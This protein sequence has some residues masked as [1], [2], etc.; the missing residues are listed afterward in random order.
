MSSPAVF[1]SSQPGFAAQQK[2]LLLKSN[3]IVSPSIH[4]L[5][6]SSSL[7]PGKLLQVELKCW[8]WLLL[9][10]M[11]KLFTT[12]LPRVSTNASSTNIVVNL[13]T[14]MDVTHGATIDKPKLNK[15]VLIILQKD[16]ATELNLLL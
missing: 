9:D 10:S 15:M 8:G 16:I 2:L 13:G 4:K 11:G 12:T 6:L 14:A 7:R 1:L 3:T 5:L